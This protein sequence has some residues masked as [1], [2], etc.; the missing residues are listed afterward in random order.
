[1]RFLA[2]LA[3]TAS[4]ALGGCASTGATGTGTAPNPTVTAT[5][6]QVQNATVNLCAFVP[7]AAT[8]AGIFASGNSL[9]SS[10]TQA[11]QL[12]CNAVAS[13]P[14]AARRG[15][16]IPVV[17]GVRIQGHFVKR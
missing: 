15:A 12:I 8:I 1:M 4:L 10:I 9:V 5:I 2:A 11:A 13:H 16:F 17:N 7:T 6:T 14:A 3:L